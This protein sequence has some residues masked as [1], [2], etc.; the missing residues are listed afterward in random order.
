[1]GFKYTSL[2]NMATLGIPDGTPI[3][4]GNTAWFADGNEVTFSDPP[5][6]KCRGDSLG[7]R[8]GA[9]VG[10]VPLSSGITR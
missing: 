5:Y 6:T 10:P 8:C 7:V 2:S 3:D 1:M 9:S 4:N